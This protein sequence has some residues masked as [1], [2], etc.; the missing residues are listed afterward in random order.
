MCTFQE[1]FSESRESAVH[2]SGS[3]HMRMVHWCSMHLAHAWDY[4]LSMLCTLQH[5][6]DHWAS[7][8]LE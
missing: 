2:F 5:E 3:M 4:M 7:I 6:C 1:I 8:L